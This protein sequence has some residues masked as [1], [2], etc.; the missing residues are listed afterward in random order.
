MVA[1]ILE[2]PVR[3]AEPPERL[4]LEED[5]GV[6]RVIFP[7]QP[8]WVYLLP[9]CMGAG[10]ALVEAVVPIGATISM[11]AYLRTVWKVHN[12]ASGSLLHLVL[13]AASG[14]WVG[15][16]VWSLVAFIGWRR[17]RRW[18]RVPRV[19]EATKDGL[20]FS[21]LSW[22]GMRQKQWPLGEINAIE[23]RPVWG[24]ITWWQTVA[25]LRIVGAKGVHKVFRLSSRDSQLP[26][27]IADRIRSMLGSPP[28][29]I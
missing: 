25:D 11:W 17:Y 27:M 7:V 13:L 3:Q 14:W 20:T 5:S 23:L 10:I 1:P 15:T 8:T 26:G 19:L 29:M 24:N 2:Y 18:G 28:S 21:Y 22:F 4:T 6:V 16:L 12:T 9:I